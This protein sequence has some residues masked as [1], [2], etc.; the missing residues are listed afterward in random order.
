[1]NNE[2]VSLL[3]VSIFHYTI[4][5]ITII[6]CLYLVTLPSFRKVILTP[7]SAEWS[8]IL[9]SFVV[10]MIGGIPVN[11]GEAISG[12]RYLYTLSFN[13]YNSFPIINFHI[14]KEYKDILFS[15]YQLISSRFLTAQY[16]FVLTAFIYVINHYFFAKHFF[17]KYVFLV[18]LMFFTGFSFY[19][20]GINTLRA[21]LAASFLLLAI[22]KRDSLLEMLFWIVVAIGFHK[23]MCIPAC[24]IVLAK[25]FDKTQI[26]LYVWLISIMVSLIFPGIFDSFLG[27]LV[28]DKRAA[29]Y[30][31][32]EGLD[33]YE[34]KFRLDFLLY[35][36]I[37][38]GIGYY[39]II[40]KKLQ[41]ANYRFLLNVYLLANSFWIIVIRAIF[42]DRFAYLS[43]FLFPILVIYPF[44]KVKI[45]KDQS[46]KIAG[47]LFLH[48]SFT[49]LMFFF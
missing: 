31:L 24:A 37:P 42:S 14:I 48:A 41:M 39:F 43:W 9:M 1:M 30:L 21:G 29:S 20:Y 44:L 3:W 4:F 8:Y 16:W 25:Y 23:S 34:R 19:A 7:L 5:F 2:Y 13:K 22:I 40:R 26:Y 36:S 28:S 27:T 45:W 33:I 32:S 38:V 18:L 17:P 12:D 49:F 15:Y 10:F 11:L 46:V 47:I 35:S 6:V